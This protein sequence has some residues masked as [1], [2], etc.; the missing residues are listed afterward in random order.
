MA[1]MCAGSY[2]SIEDQARV[3][4]NEPGMPE[5]SMRTYVKSIEAINMLLMT[6]YIEHLRPNLPPGM[7]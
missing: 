7:W 4:H 2:P 6:I 1:C 5:W 3:L